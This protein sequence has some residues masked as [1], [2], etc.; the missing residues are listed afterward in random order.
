[1]HGYFRICNTCCAVH[2]HQ[3]LRCTV[4]DRISAL[5]SL[6]SE[7]R[8]HA[9]GED[10]TSRHLRMAGEHRVDGRQVRDDVPLHP[11]YSLPALVS[12]MYVK[13][14]LIIL[15]LDQCRASPCVSSYLGPLNVAF[16]VFQVRRRKAHTFEEHPCHH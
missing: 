1:M 3:Q 10:E 6:P 12:C 15:A 7:V 13:L 11:T 2:H 8:R 16:R 9:G 4:P 14:T 5:Y